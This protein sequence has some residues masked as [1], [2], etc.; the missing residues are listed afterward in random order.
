[1]STAYFGGGNLHVI[2]P[3]SRQ[4]LKT[5]HLGGAARRVV[6]HSSGL[7]VIPNEGGWVDF[8]R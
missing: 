7:G 8:I 3:L 6:F 2:N 4:L 5:Y 1:V